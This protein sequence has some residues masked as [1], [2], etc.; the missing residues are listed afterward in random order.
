VNKTLATTNLLIAK[1]DG[2]EAGLTADATYTLN[3]PFGNVIDDPGA[4]PVYAVSPMAT[5]GYTNQFV[6][7]STSVPVTFLGTADSIGT[8]CDLTGLTSPASD[9]RAGGIQ[10]LHFHFSG[11]PS[12][13]PTVQEGYCTV[14]DSGYPGTCAPVWGALSG[15]V[16][17]CT[18]NGSNLECTFTPALAD[19]KTYEFDMAPITGTTDLFQIKGLIGDAFADGFV[20]GSDRSTV[21]ANWDTVGPVPPAACA[22]DVF[23]DTKC[24]GSDR[25]TVH[26][27]WGD[28]A[29]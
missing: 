8:V 29:P 13:S 5:I 23:E 9:S 22:A 1:S 24:D 27:N 14:C 19:D 4:G 21:H 26:A 15:S 16:M 3:N 25:S 17:N 18:P 7:V 20:D 2:N 10:E 28:C 11:P 6:V 12:G